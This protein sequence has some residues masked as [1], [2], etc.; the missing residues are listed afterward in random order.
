MG[1]FAEEQIEITDRGFMPKLWLE[2]DD[3]STLPWHGVSRVINTLGRKATYRWQ[4][5]TLCTQR[6]R[7]RLGPLTLRTGDPLGIFNMVRHMTASGYIVVYPLT[8]ELPA[9]SFEPSISDLAGGEA[10]TAAHTK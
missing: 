2:V 8:V 5:R 6:G 10:V 4:V 9:V 3:E 7:F 1:Q